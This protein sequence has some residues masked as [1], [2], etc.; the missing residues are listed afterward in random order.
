MIDRRAPTPTNRTSASV[1]P[2]A[3]E[4]IDLVASR[5]GDSDAFRTA[6]GMEDTTTRLVRR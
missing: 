2:S 6:W 1:P 3:K 5:R 4:K